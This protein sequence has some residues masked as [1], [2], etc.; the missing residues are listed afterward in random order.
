MTRPV[1]GVD[2]IPDPWPPVWDDGALLT[3][4]ELAE[5][6]RDERIAD[7]YRAAQ[8]AQIEPCEV[9]GDDLEACARFEAAAAAERIGMANR[10]EHV[11]HAT[12]FRLLDRIDA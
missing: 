10:E 5:L 11:A 7:A 12:L 6:E 3:T 4:G 8:L 9:H 1:F 2:R